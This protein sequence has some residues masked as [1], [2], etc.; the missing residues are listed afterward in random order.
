MSQKPPVKRTYR[1]AKEMYPLIEGWQ[2][3][4]LS[5]KIYSQKHAVPLLVFRYWLRRYRHG[6]PPPRKEAADF[7]SL[8]L[9]KEFSE[10]VL[11]ELVYPNGMRL[12]FKASVRPE[13]LRTFLPND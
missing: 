12:V 5:Q 11:A 8:E 10:K 9:E 7:I 6:H 13:V 1:T 2:A 3:S 4:G